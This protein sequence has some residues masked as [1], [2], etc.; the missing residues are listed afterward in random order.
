M[1]LAKKLRGDT[2]G[3]E[4]ARC[5]TKAMLE[6][7]LPTMAMQGIGGPMFGMLEARGYTLILQGVGGPIMVTSKVENPKLATLKVG[8]L[9]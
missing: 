3:H 8:L 4:E 1:Q 2:L 5:P 9:M 6:V 7:C